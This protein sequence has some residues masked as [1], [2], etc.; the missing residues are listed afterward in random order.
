MF[1]NSHWEELASQGYTVV[2]GAVGQ[3]QLQA[4]QAAARQLN[5]SH[6]DGGWERTRNESW[7]EVRYCRHPAFMAIA[8]DVLDP[9]ALEILESAPPIDFV[10]F[11]STMPG[12]VTKGGIGRNFHIDGGTEKVLGVFNIIFGCAL[13]DVA[14]DTVGGFH[15]L[16]GSHH[17]FAKAFEELPADAPIP[18]G[19]IKIETQREL[20]PGARMVVPRLA[21]GD[22]VVAHSFLAHGTSANLSDMRRDMIFQRRAASPMWDPATQV[23]AREQFMRD[24][25]T[26]FRR[27]P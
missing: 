11:A 20:L 5:E 27:H 14:S 19:N 12:F 8:S 4:A 3:P 9:L 24:P 2:S 25:W 6:P 17:A 23:S 10:Q 16:P 15:V 21:A 22:I 13:T 1:E 26:M 7:R 18:F